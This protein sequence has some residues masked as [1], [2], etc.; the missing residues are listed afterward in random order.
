MVGLNGEDLGHPA[1]GD[2]AAAGP[3]GAR[4]PWQALRARHALRLLRGEADDQ[5][6]Q[7]HRLQPQP[8]PAAADA[9]EAPGNVEPR[10]A[11]VRPLDD[12]DNRR[13]HL[14]SGTAR[15]RA[16][17]GIMLPQASAAARPLSIPP[18]HSTRALPHRVGKAF[19]QPPGRA[20]LADAR[21]VLEAEGAEAPAGPQAPAWAVAAER[22]SCYRHGHRR[23]GWGGASGGVR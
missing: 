23:V 9:Q 11:V 10:V 6:T 4:V 19:C 2:D 21:L 1:R 16:G 8:L 22:W 5:G 17:A 15:R 14:P 20:R 7:R 3:F 12:K 13:H 18:A